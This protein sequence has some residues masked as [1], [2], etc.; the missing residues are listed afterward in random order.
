MPLAD[1]VIPPAFR[2]VGEKKAKPAAADQDVPAAPLPERA[3]YVPGIPQGGLNEYAQA[4]GASTGTD[5]RTQMQE[6]YD[7]YVTCT[8]S[9][10]C[11]QVT[12]RTVTAG[13]LFTDW[14]SDTQ[15]GDQEEPDKPPEVVALERFYSFCNPTQ[16]IRQILR[17]AVADLLVFGDALFEVVW[18]GPVP[19]ALY[20]QDVVTTTPTT[21]EHGEISKWVQVTDYGQRAE[22]EPREIIHVSLDS[23]RPGMFGVSPT[24]AM[25]TAIA[26]WLFAAA[27]EEEMLRKGLPPTVHADLPASYSATESERWRNQAAAQNLGSANIGVPWVTKNGG[28][29]AELQ[30]GKLADVLEAKDRA[31]DEIVAGYGVPPAQAFI[32]ESGNLGGGTGDSQFRSYMINTCDPIGAILLE[33]LNYHIAW[34]GFGVKGWRSKFREVDYRD[35][36]VIEQIRDT[37]VR[38]GSWTRNRYAA[39]IGEPTV[40]GGDVP[41]LVERQAIIA[42]KDIQRYSDAQIAQAE[43]AAATAGGAAPPPRQESLEGRRARL[44]EALAAYHRAGQ[45]TEGAVVRPESGEDIAQAVYA[46]LAP[47]FPADAIAWVK[48]AAWEG[49]V[50]VPADQIDMADRDQW[51]ASGEPSKVAALVRKLRGKHAKGKTLKP[52]ILVRADG[53]DTDIIADGHHRVLAYLQAAQPVYAYVGRV[54]AAT[55]PWTAMG[56]AQRKEAA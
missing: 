28:K 9:W 20:N 27:T 46:Q 33:K 48:D 10:V 40:E 3:G 12:A 14:D 42:W 25:L 15:E 47:D 13:G 21:D 34:Q 17:N 23:A 38:N 51:T 50:R 16:D 54:K 36:V 22:F 37:R 39:E 1:W 7:S 44:R 19:V 32:I 11:V 31:R 30:A 45:I 5:R 29:L 4:I 52:V 26:S 35:S 55:G 43:A 24:Q 49:P 56:A 41:V 18:N 8:W 53:S 2:R 6:L